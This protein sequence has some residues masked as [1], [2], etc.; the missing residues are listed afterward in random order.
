[1][2]LSVRILDVIYLH[3]KHLLLH[4]HLSKLLLLHHYG[5]VKGVWTTSR[6]HWH[7]HS[8]GHGHLLHWILWLLSPPALFLFLLRFNYFVSQ[9]FQHNW[10]SLHKWELLVL[11]MWHAISILLKHFLM[12]VFWKFFFVHKFFYHLL[13][14]VF[15][16]VE[17]NNQLLPINLLI[18]QTLQSLGR[19]I[20][21]L[22]RN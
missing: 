2:W 10:V 20:L 11:L 7:R 9:I 18:I 22:K 19:L 5:H 8:H 4:L 14:H 6:R 15:G 16:F 21:S 17:F 12:F 3:H 1:M 13:F